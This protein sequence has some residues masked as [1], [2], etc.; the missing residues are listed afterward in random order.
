[1]IGRHLL[2]CGDA[3]ESIGDWCR[4]QCGPKGHIN[5]LVKKLGLCELDFRIQKTEFF[6]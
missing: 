6:K 2:L 5:K 4:P 3:V 1:L